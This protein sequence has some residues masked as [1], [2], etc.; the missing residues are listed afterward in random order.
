MAAVCLHTAVALEHLTGQMWAAEM[1]LNLGSCSTP[2]TGQLQECNL[3]STSAAFGVRRPTRI[4][5]SDTRGPGRALGWW[6]GGPP[7]GWTELGN[8]SRPGTGP[9]ATRIAASQARHS[10]SPAPRHL[11]SANRPG[12]NH[13]RLRQDR[14]EAGGNEIFEDKLSGHRVMADPDDFIQES[15]A[16]RG[17]SMGGRGYNQEGEIPTQPQKNGFE[18]PKFPVEIREEAA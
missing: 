4:P 10:T 9:Q 5:A 2:T 12:R 3:K 15:R 8:L 7:A 13:A 1:T 14:D 17:K 18:P 6:R 11:P 16:W